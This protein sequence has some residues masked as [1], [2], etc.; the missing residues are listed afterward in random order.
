MT[1][2]KRLAWLFL[3]AAMVRSCGNSLPR[4]YCSVLRYLVDAYQMIGAAIPCPPLMTLSP[5]TRTPHENK[6]LS[7]P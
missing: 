3:A 1:S 6:E 5:R 2:L 4:G 7:R